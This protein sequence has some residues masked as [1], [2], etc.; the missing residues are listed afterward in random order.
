MGGKKS[1]HRH[2]MPLENL[3]VL[4]LVLTGMMSASFGVSKQKI[5]A[6]SAGRCQGV[7]QTQPG[8]CCHCATISARSEDPQPSLPRGTLHPCAGSTV[9]TST[10]ANAALH[11]LT[12]A[13][14]LQLPPPRGQP[15]P[16]LRHLLLLYLGLD[17]ALCLR[18][19]RPG[20]HSTYTS[21]RV[22]GLQ[23]TSSPQP[24]GRLAVQTARERVETHGGCRRGGKRHQA[25]LQA[26]S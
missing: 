5:P 18:L 12:L 10:E 19:D 15:P 25:A 3:M 8:V 24:A 17:R 14:L 26:A 22:A 7:A 9:Q 4:T 6:G 13:Q 20:C 2:D 11:A 21:P 1:L 23:Y 16:A